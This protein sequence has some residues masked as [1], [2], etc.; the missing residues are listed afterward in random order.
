M[1]KCAFLFP[2]QGSQEIGMGSDLI[3]KDCFTDDLLACASD[4]VNEDLSKL[5]LYGPAEKLKEARFLQPTLVAVCLGYFKHLLANG[6]IPDV[7]SGHSLGEITSLGASEVVSPE[8][9]IRIAIKRGELMDSVAQRIKGGMLAVLFVP[10]ETV[11][12]LIDDIDDGRRLVIAND[13]APDQV[14]ISGENELLDRFAARVALEKL[15]KCLRV[16]VAGPWHSPFMKE[17]QEIFRKWIS[18]IPFL[19]PKY[20]VVFNGTASTE[21]DPSIIKQLITRQLTE[22]VYWRKC[23]AKIKSMGVNTIYEIGPQKKLSGLA[24]LNGFNKSN[25]IYNINNL[26]CMEKCLKSIVS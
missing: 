25:I 23:M 3:G 14:V 21:N 6:I 16:D 7:I 11:K 5:C 15:G 8:L 4:I 18:D 9:C 26:T 24:R 22:T 1:V 12:R 10:L 2:G 19:P 13:N 17:S 20:P